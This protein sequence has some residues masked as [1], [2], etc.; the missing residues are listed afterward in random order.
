MEVSGNVHEGIL[1]GNSPGSR[2]H[3]IILTA[4]FCSLKTPLKE[5]DDEVP[6]KRVPY[7]TTIDLT[8]CTKLAANP[9]IVKRGVR[10]VRGVVYSYL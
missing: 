1:L 5:D 9:A 4:I 2:D 7:D 6:Q 3:K 10:G 8:F